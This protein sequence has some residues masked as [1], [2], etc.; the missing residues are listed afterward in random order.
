M[1][2]NLFGGINMAKKKYYA[3]RKGNKTGIFESWTECETSVSGYSNAEYQ[4]FSS[5]DDAVSF[6]ENEDPSIKVFQEAERQESLIA[7]TD[8]SFSDETKKYS[9]GCVIITPEQEI[10]KEFNCGN[11]NEALKSR[12]VAGE[13]YGVMFVIQWAVSHGY[14]NVKIRYDYEGI[15]KWATGLWKVNSYVAITYKKFLEKYR[16]LINF[17]FEKVEAHSGDKYNEEAD[18]LAKKALG[19]KRKKT[20]NYGASWFTVEGVSVDEI[21][22]ILDIMKKEEIPE[23]IVTDTDSSLKKVFFARISSDKITIQH[24]YA[25][26]I[27]VI[28]GKPRTVFNLFISYLTQLLDVDEITPVLNKCYSVDVEKDAVKKQY[29]I[30]LPSVPDTISDK[31]KNSLLQSIFNLNYTGP[32][33]EFTYLVTPIFRALE[34]HLKIILS[35]RGIQ[36]NGKSI[37]CFEPDLLDQSYKLKNCHHSKC[38]G[39]DEIDYLSKAYTFYYKQ[40]HELSHWDWPFGSVDTTRVVESKEEADEIIKEALDLINKYYILR[41]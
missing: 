38:S 37:N 9:F 41:C 18:Q 24:F 2:R 35:I 5:Y 20:T 30:Y 22:D 25:K 31:L 28:Q 34:G 13:I 6:L 17:S 14:D 33:F 4:S 39:T 19:L 7:Y 40:R 10:I 16:E 8:G 27:T 36:S 23:L 32:M 11:N 26:S 15:E 3:V 29:D 1:I 21:R 12:N